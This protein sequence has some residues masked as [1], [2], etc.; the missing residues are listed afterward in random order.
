[1]EGFFVAVRRRALYAAFLN[2]DS[3][4]TAAGAKRGIGAPATK[5]VG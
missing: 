4:L 2:K 3:K 5:L 1:M